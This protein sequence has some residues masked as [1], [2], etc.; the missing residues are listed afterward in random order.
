MAFVL[1]G[2]LVGGAMLYFGYRI[3]IGAYATIDRHAD[4]L[5]THDNVVVRH[6]PTDLD[7]IPANEIEVPPWHDSMRSEPSNEDGHEWN[8]GEAQEL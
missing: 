4:S 1:V 7:T 3:G 6:D 2:A 8:D 5:K